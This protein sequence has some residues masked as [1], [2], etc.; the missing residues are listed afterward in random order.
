[1]RLRHIEIFHAIYTTG[2]ITNA[3]KI[4]HV[5]QPSVSKVLSHAELQLGFNLFERVKGRLIPT[6]EAEM[7]F[8]EVDKIYQQMRSIKNTALN[9]KKSEFGS[10]SLG[11][12]PALGFDAIPNVIAQYHHDYPHV[13]FD[14]QTTHNDAVVQSLLE[15]KSDLAI[16][17]SP[18]TM[19]GITAIPLTTSE[20]VIVYPKNKFPDCPT[21]LTLTEICDS[22]FI[23]ISD[24]GPLAEMLWAR[25]LEEDINFEPSSIK[26]Q[27]YFIAVR[28]VTRGLGVCVVDRYTAEGNLSDNIAIASFDPPLAF[29]ISAI[30][31]DTLTK[32]KLIDE[33]I[34]YLIRGI[35]NS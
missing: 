2:S 7:L 35:S 25:A 1:M 11:V 27:T 24:S 8:G 12:T 13:T 28:L 15:Y 29:N 33:F 16:L 23:D 20:L 4:L 10:I 21:K 6:D 17:F 9:I 3:A 26:V 5:S 14:I 34:P 30:H 32:S 22:E 31:L 18:H 19:P